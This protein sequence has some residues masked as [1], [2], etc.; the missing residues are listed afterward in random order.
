MDELKV[1]DIMRTDVITVGPRATVRDLA[2][3]LAEHKV[4]GVPVVDEGGRLLGIVT[5]GD[6]I[7]QDTD[8][9]FPHYVQFLESVIYLESVRK[10]EERFKKAFG[11]KVA[12][13]MSEDVF[14]VSPDA[15]VREAATLMADHEVNRVPVIDED[16]VVVG[17]VTRADVVRAIA[18]GEA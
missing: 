1:R 10:F 11:S 15:S 17:I 6:V 14:T 3:L 18:A 4:S 13:V 16:R 9:H 5:E 8:L 2:G 12:D 7:I